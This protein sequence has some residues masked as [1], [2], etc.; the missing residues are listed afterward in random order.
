MAIPT[1]IARSIVDPA[2]YAAGT[3]VDEAFTILR[4]DMPFDRTQ[5]DDYDPFW[6]ASRH[7]DIMEIERQ[8]DLFVSSARSSLLVSKEADAMVRHF[9]GGDP[10]LARALTS[11]DGLEHKQLRGVTF[12]HFS[13]RNIS[14]LQDKV[15]D[16]ARQFVARMIAN[17]TTCDFAADVAFYYPLR[18]IMQLLGIPEE[19]EPNLLR[20]TQQVFS[21]NDPDLNRHLKTVTPEQAQAGFINAIADLEGYF[22]E[23]TKKLRAHPRDD[24]NSAIANARVNGEYLNRRQLMGYYIIAATAGH[25]TTSN[26]TAGAMWALAERPELFA[27]LKSNPER[28]ADF[29]EE[30]I[31]WATPVKHFMRTATADVEFR[32]QKIAN[33]DWIMLSYHSANRDEDVFDSPSSFDIDRPAKHIAF[34]YGPHVCLGQHL[35]RLEMRLFWE[36]L[37]PRLRSIELAGTPQLTH[38][39]FVCGPKTVPV[40]FSLQ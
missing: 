7:A 12:P 3:P 13:P 29:V 39:N 40:R 20:L 30:S 14:K 37:I 16:T 18:V 6:V 32:G 35:A 28:I 11:V 33:G 38:S 1:H 2:A 19:D 9:T 15:R 31:R 17:G 21:S 25:D 23:V 34:G 8:P 36:E 4:R 22:E 24:I 27:K 26:T 10:N 5:L